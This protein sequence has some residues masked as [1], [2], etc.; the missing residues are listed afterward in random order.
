[1]SIHTASFITNMFFSDEPVLPVGAVELSV[2]CFSTEDDDETLEVITYADSLAEAC[3]VWGV[4][5]H[6]AQDGVSF[7]AAP[8]FTTRPRYISKA[9][10][11]AEAAE[12][13]ALEA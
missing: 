6:P 8:L 4:E 13:A 5:F 2:Q 9:W 11:L 1:M 7:G 3:S 10:L 12:V